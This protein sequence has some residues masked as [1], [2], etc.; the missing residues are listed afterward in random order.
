ME[1][2]LN[3]VI[4]YTR[5]SSD[6]QRTERLSIENQERALTTYCE[7]KGFRIIGNAF[8]EDYSAR[9]FDMKRPEIKKIYEYCKNNKGEIDKILFLRWDR[10]SRNVEFAFTYKRLFMDELGVEINAIEEPIDFNATDWPIWLSIRCGVAHTEDNKIARRTQEGIHEHLMRGEWCGIAPIGYKNIKANEETGTDHYIVIDPV[11]GDTVRK[12]FC[13]VAKG[14][15]TPAEIRRRLLPKVSKSSFFKMLKNRFYI[16]KISVPAFMD[17]PA[18]EV[19]GRHPAL[20]DED[21]FNAVQD[22]MRGKRKNKPRSGK[23]TNP[24]LY[25]R[26]YLVCPVCGHRITGATSKGNGGRYDYYCCNHDHKHLNIR[27]EKA[28]ELF[29][30]YVS[31][32]TPTSFAIDMYKEILKDMRGYTAKA[33]SITIS[34]IQKEIEK[35]NSRISKVND[36]FFDGEINKADREEQLARYTKDR[37]DLEMRIKALKTSEEL[38]LKDKVDYSMSLVENLAYYFANSTAETKTKIL[39]SIFNS[40][41]VFDGENYRT[42]EFNNVLKYIYDNINELQ[43]KTKTELSEKS[44]NSALV[45]RRGIEPR[46]KV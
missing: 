11:I 32:L 31:T 8:Y 19:Q 29:Q 2:T 30:E 5:V 34:K 24:N 42:T 22:I 28:N 23:H 1:K 35:I 26:K 20:I 36:A 3:N 13:E 38:K 10:Y 37:K 27:A 39:G 7:A 18:T 25:L 44:D 43:G 45:A 21:T 33:N 40:E 17:Y 14:L 9:D 4:L 41:I 6:E 15:E 16:G 12:V 46:F